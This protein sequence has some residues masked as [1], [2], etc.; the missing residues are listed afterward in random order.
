MKHIVLIILMHLSLMAS[1][2]QKKLQF[3]DMV[4]EPQIK[5]VQLHPDLSIEFD[6]LQDNRSNYYA[7]LIH[8]NFDWTKSSLTD[9][10]FINEYN[11]FTLNEYEISNNI[12][13]AYVHYRFQIPSV[14]FQEITYWFFTAMVTYLILYFRRDFL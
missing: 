1:A 3:I 6:D 11:E 12:Y 9:L 7:K 2:Q 10:D 4:Y 14:R 5:T 8:C 13:P